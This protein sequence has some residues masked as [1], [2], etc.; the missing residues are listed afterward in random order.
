VTYHD[1]TVVTVSDG[2]VLSELS[3]RFRIVDSGPNHVV[4]E[5]E[6]GDEKPFA[7]TMTSRIEFTPDGYWTTSAMMAPPFKMKFVKKGS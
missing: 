4:V 7:K 5:I 3:G 2:T 1:D 6:P